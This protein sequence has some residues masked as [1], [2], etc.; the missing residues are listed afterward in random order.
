MRILAAAALGLGL[1]LVA[2]P[3][4]AD[5]GDAASPSPRPPSVVLRH[6]DAP[7]AS[8][9]PA[10]R[11]VVVLV[12][13]FASA[14]DDGLFDTMAA[15]LRG[16]GYDVIRF[17]DDPRF[18]YD[19][20][21]SVEAN[22]RS[23][24]AQIR[25]VARR[26]NV[27][28]VTHSMGGVVA[29][30]ALAQGLGR[31]DRVAT[32]IA[33]SSPHSGS[34]LAAIVQ[35][36]LG[37]SGDARADLVGMFGRAIDSDAVRDLARMTPAPTP[38]DVVRVD[39]REATDWTVGRGDARSKGVIS[40]TLPS[41][42][43]D[44]HGDILRSDVAQDLIERTIAERRVPVDDRSARLAA[45]GAVQDVLLDRWRTLALTCLLFGACGLALALRLRRVLHGLRARRRPVW[46]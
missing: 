1:L 19:T 6:V 27:H 12:G 28:I 14:P 43:L 8:V 23:L 42:A 41:A 13:G 9:A 37:V 2:H 26:G 45:A 40:R 30:A 29:D 36:A 18:A 4:A 39:L 38:R 7:V 16:A 33:L 31:S 35:L 24:S 17:G 32:Y 10:H 46:I 5:G 21:G 25:A 20:T 34:S 11:D 22:A 3:A 15:G 44:G